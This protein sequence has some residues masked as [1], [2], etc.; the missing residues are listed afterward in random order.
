MV[1]SRKSPCRRAETSGLKNSARPCDDRQV[2]GRPDRSGVCDIA[3][4]VGSRSVL[5]MRMVPERHRAGCRAG[6][7]AGNGQNAACDVSRIMVVGR[8]RVTPSR[9]LGIE[10][11]LQSRG[12]SDRVRVSGGR[13]TAHRL[14]AI[15]GCLQPRG[16][17]D[18]V[19]V[20]GRR[21]GARLVSKVVP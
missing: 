8:C 18:R 16:I 5:R 21:E 17:G 11:C 2:R 14:L 10:G 20:G 19:A 15:K 6:G 9:L 13:V 3:V 12:I 1:A 4:N 7:D